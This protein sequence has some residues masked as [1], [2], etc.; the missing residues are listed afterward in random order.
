MVYQE[1]LLFTDEI[2]L[3]T[4]IGTLANFVFVGLMVLASLGWQHAMGYTAEAFSLFIAAWALNAMLD[5]ISCTVCSAAYGRYVVR[6]NEVVGDA[7]KLYHHF[8]AQGESGLPGVFLTI[9]LF[10]VL[11]FTGF[12]LFSVYYLRLHHNGRLLDVYRR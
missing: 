11:V 2:V 8:D 12:V 5:P 4:L 1:N 9:F 6:P 7:F 3:L 10:F